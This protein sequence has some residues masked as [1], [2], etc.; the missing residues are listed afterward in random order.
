MPYVPLEQFLD[1]GRHQVG[2]TYDAF[3][4][5]GSIRIVV[6]VGT[7]RGF[8]EPYKSKQLWDNLSRVD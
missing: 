5:S 7:A 8:V 2:G 3:E 1:G 4:E 6:L